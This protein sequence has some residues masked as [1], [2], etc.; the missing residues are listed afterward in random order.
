MD[1]TTINKFDTTDPV[2]QSWLKEI[3]H[4]KDVEDLCITFTK[5]NG[6]VRNLHCTLAES[7]IPT[8]KQ[9]KGEATNRTA[10]A[11]AQAVFDIDL[12]EWR[13]FRWDSIKE[14]SFSA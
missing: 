8:G 9:P 12:G 4:D 1:K 10:S 14:V 2:F 5:Q 6:E 7:K 11:D 13:S 3:L